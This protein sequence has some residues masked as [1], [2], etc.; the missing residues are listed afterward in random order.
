MYPRLTESSVT[1]SVLIVADRGTASPMT[2]TR[3]GWE[4]K[5]KNAGTCMKRK[6]QPRTC[7]RSGPDLGM[8]S[9]YATT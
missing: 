3:R 1:P 7:L 9:V 6:T 2:S 4:A 8:V 5:E